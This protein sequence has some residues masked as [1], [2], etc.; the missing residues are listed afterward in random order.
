[1]SE[2]SPREIDTLILSFG[3]ARWRKVAMVIA[4]VMGEAAR[5]GT[6]V[7]EYLVGERIRAMVQSNQ[8]EGQGELWMW[9]Q[10][11]VKLP[12]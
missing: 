6:P 2:L 8:L 11:E 4:K 3:Y 7:D 12:G 10:S 9:R 1:M 5:R